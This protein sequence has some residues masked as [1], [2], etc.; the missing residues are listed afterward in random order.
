[1]V[2]SRPL[3]RVE[4]L[5]VGTRRRL[6]T[7]QLSNSRPRRHAEGVRPQRHNEPLAYLLQLWGAHGPPRRASER[8]RVGRCGGYCGPAYPS[9]DCYFRTGQF[10]L[11]WGEL[12]HCSGYPHNEQLEQPVLQRCYLLPAF[13]HILL[14][15][16]DFCGQ[17]GPVQRFHRNSY[18][19]YFRREENKI[20]TAGRE[21]GGADQV[22]FRGIGRKTNRGT[23]NGMVSGGG[24]GRIGRNR[25]ERIGAGSGEEIWD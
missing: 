3:P 4:G 13:H 10:R 9:G 2:F 14:H 15:R 8:L 16:L 21:N 20:S 11:R 6:A 1:M 17:L 19:R 7:H 24:Q 18:P 23:D 22:F 12:P 5:R 25:H